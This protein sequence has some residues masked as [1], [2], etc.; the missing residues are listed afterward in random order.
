[1]YPGQRQKMNKNS[2]VCLPV[3]A[4]LRNYAFQSRDRQDRDFGTPVPISGTGT[5]NLDRV[6]N[7]VGL[8]QASLLPDMKSRLFATKI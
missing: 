7:W 8:G 3:W 2:L 6:E 1:M 4:R 5:E